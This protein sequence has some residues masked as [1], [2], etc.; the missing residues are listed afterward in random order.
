MCSLIVLWG[1]KYCYLHFIEEET[2]IQRS[3][4]GGAWVVQSVKC[5]TLGFGS[6]RDLRVMR[7]SPTLNVESA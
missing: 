7:W 1:R 2:D 4:E 3:E 6:G 5:P